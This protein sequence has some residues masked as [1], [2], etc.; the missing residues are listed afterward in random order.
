[1]PKVLWSKTHPADEANRVDMVSR[2]LLLVGVGRVILV[3]S[4]I[5]TTWGDKE[6]SIYALDPTVRLASS[7][8]A[9][10]VPPE[11][12]THVI[13]THLHFDHAGGNT[14]PEGIPAF[15]NAIY[16]V[17]R[18]HLEWAR[19]PSVRDAASFAPRVWEILEQ[20]GQ[21]EPVEGGRELFPG[22][23]LEVVHGHTPHQQLPRITDGG[24]TLLFCSDLVP[25]ASQVRVPWVMGYDLRP[26]DTVREKQALL[27][28]AAREGWRL[29]LEHDPIYETCRVDVTDKGP[30]AVSPGPL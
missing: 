10:G 26:V 24:E 8:Q 2:S 28:R 1:V 20:S 5:G 11:R 12:V 25:F 14:T 29:F 17:Q 7:L 3:N 18:G 19:R 30:T 15:P 22:I 6:R 4:G 13:L 21:L 16:L 9:L 27:S 23:W